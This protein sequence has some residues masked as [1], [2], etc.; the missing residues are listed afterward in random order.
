[1]KNTLFIALVS[2]MFSAGCN[3][4]KQNDASVKTTDSLILKTDSD[5]AAMI[6]D[7][8]YLFV[9]AKDSYA[10]RLNFEGKKVTGKAIFKN[11]QKDSSHGD[12][13]GTKDGDNIHLWYHFLSEG[14]ESYSELYLKV[15]GEQLNSG[16]G[17]IL[18]QGD[19][20]F[21]KDKANLTFG[22]IIYSKTGCDQTPLR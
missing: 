14:M 7:Q 16:M 18:V 1:M 5:D 3:P 21:L 11:Y 10:L 6:K 17:E 2:I 20:A 15:E 19:S 13:S 4:Q 22:S 8:C 12:V 9:A